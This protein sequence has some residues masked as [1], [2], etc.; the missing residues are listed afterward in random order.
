MALNKT[1]LRDMMISKM[2]NKPDN[3]PDAFENLA[4]AFIEYILDN[5]EVEIPAGSIVG[6]VT[7]GSGAP[8]VGIPNNT[9][10]KCRVR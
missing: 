7:G 9:S 5:I 3:S 6:S 8:A 1:E 4:D 2:S 10:I